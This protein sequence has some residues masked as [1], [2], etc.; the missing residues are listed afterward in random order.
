MEGIRHE[1]FY[2]WP[3]DEVDGVVRERFDHILNR[4]NPNPRPFG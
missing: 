1:Q 3:G 4:T 2:I